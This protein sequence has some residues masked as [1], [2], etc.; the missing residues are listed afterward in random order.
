MPTLSEA[1]YK[2]FPFRA[3][4]GVFVPRGTPA[5]IVARLNAD[6]GGVLADPEVRDKVLVARGLEP[7]PMSPGQFAQYLKEDRVRAGELVKQSGIQI[8]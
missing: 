7:L 8:E 2:G 6:F 1:G 4:Y 3:W 5:P